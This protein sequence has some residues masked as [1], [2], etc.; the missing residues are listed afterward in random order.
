MHPSAKKNCENFFNIYCKGRNLKILDVGSLDVNGSLRDIFI[1][2]YEYVGIDF[3]SGKNV[4][5]VLNDPYNFP[6]PNENF[7]VVICSSVFEHSQ[8]FW[9]L[10]IELLRVTNQQGLIYI[11]APSNGYIHRFPVDCWRFYPDAGV[12]L[13][14][15]ARQND[16]KPK[17]LESF[18][19]SKD[20]VNIRS[21]AWNDFV[22]IFVRDELYANNY[23]SRINN[24]DKNSKNVFQDGSAIEESISKMPDDFNLIIDLQNN[25]EYYIRYIN[26]L[27]NSLNKINDKLEIT[28]SNVIALKNS[29]S[30]R[31]T[32]P[33]RYIKDIFKKP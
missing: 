30:W 2:D 25:K 11:N 19:A 15:W 26:Y 32:A 28:K 20:F 22:A 14:N 23:P 33:L 6:F 12:A 3:S 16:F 24:L 31:V 18:T 10:F 21:D 7:D 8:F 9:K 29:R 5:I 17:L 1:G 4:D 13:E 27:E